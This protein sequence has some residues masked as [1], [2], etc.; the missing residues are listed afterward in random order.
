MWGRQVKSFFK[1]SKGSLGIY[2][3]GGAPLLLI[4]SLTLFDVTTMMQTR[5]GMQDTMDTALTAAL[6]KGV[7]MKLAGATNAVILAETKDKFETYYSN[8]FAQMSGQSGYTLS[9][10][11]YTLTYDIPGNKLTANL[12][13]T[14]PSTMPGP[15]QVGNHDISVSG[16]VEMSETPF[17]Y[18]IDI[19]MCLDATGSMSS[20]LNAVK[21]KAATF[22]TDLRT[23]LGVNGGGNNIKVRVKP[24][25]YRD[26]TDSVKLK[27]AG[28]IDLDPNLGSGQTQ[29]TQNFALES[30]LGSESASGGG[31]WP[32]A[33][34]A[35]LYEG[36]HADWMDETS[37][38]AQQYF[39]DKGL[40][41]V[42]I[43]NVP[44]VV[45]WTD[46]PISSLTRTRDHVH[47]QVPTSYSTFEGQWDDSGNIQQDRKILLQFG[48][49]SGAG[50]NTVKN[51]DRFVYGGSLATGNS[52][53]VTIIAQEIKKSVPELLRISS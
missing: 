42:P 9:A 40:G 8:N 12:I 3:A 27:T 6:Q 28:F 46:A 35:C 37:T 10:N 44:V 21:A 13:Y 49:S 5:S 18:V 25:F 2:F 51:W 36:I 15:F 31:D 20:T 1:D 7:E 53:A 29:A 19:V 41:G 26:Y 11:N 23:E 14:S 34:G 38:V 16:S 45:F 17:N 47:A 52:S 48:P 50:W 32:E 4:S 24:Y 33:A 43:L 39:D 22:N 30:F